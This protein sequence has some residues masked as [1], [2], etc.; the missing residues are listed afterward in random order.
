MTMHIKLV[1]SSQAL[2]VLQDIGILQEYLKNVSVSYLQVV[3]N[4]VTYVT[5]FQ[6]TVNICINNTLYHGGDSNRGSS[7]PEETMAT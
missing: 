4:H 6:C 1:L 3:I 7:V 5:A 2:F